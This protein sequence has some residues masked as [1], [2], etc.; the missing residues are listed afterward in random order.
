M[1]FL[2]MWVM[3]HW[4]ETLRLSSPRPLCC[5][6]PMDHKSKSS[7]HSSYLPSWGS[8]APTYQRSFQYICINTSPAENMI[9]SSYHFCLFFFLLLFFSIILLAHSHPVTDWHHQ[10]HL[11]CHLLPM[12][13]HVLAS[14]H[15]KQMS[16]C[17]L[18][19]K[20]IGFKPVQTCQLLLCACLL[21]PS[22]RTHWPYP[23]I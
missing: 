4:K 7:L 12:T 19:V 5:K 20:P 22:I 9:I 14:C 6:P 21:A 11:F 8:H 2:E 13:S 10:V 1:Y 16:C 18:Q 23:T 17:G 3:F 15:Q